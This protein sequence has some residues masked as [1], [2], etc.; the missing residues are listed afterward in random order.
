MHKKIKKENAQGPVSA[1]LITASVFGLKMALDCNKTGC[2][3][4]TRSLWSKLAASRRKR[5]GKGRY[6]LC[7]E[8][9]LQL[10]AQLV[11]LVLHDAGGPEPRPGLHAQGRVPRALPHRVEARVLHGRVA[12]L[13]HR[14]LR[15][16]LLGEHRSLLLHQDARLLAGERLWVDGLALRKYVNNRN[17]WRDVAFRRII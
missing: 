2:T 17:S 6:L 15:R 16:V 10:E 13:R 7:L 14:S 4:K 3:V 8:P 9:V 12:A 1:K 11:G 5:A